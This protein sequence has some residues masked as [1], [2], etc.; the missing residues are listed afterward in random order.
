MNIKEKCNVIFHGFDNINKLL[1]PEYLKSQH[2][3]NPVFMAGNNIHEVKQLIRNK[4]KD[5]IVEKS[6]NIRR[7]KFNYDELGTPIPVDN[8]IINTLSQYSFSYLEM[9]PDATGWNFSFDERKRFYYEVLTYWNTVLIRLKPKICIFFTWPHN[10]DCLALYLLCKHVYK[11]NVLFLDPVPLLNNHFHLVNNSLEELHKPISEIYLSDAKLEPSVKVRK[12]LDSIRGEDVKSPDYILQIYN[13]NNHNL[14]QFCIKQLYIFYKQLIKGKAF[15]KGDFDW[16]I[17][18]KPFYLPQSQMNYFDHLMFN[19]RIAVNNRKLVRYYLPRCIKPE[20]NRKYL[21]FAAP[22]QPE[23]VTAS[24]SM[25]YEDIFLVLDILSKVI[26]DDWCIYYKEHPATFVESFRGS[27]K[28]DK[29][30]YD[31]LNDYQNIYMISTDISTFEMIDHC[32]AV[33]TVSGTVSWEAINRGKPALS[34]GNAWYMGCKS[35][36]PINTYEDAIAA[37]SEIQNGFRPDYE[38]I[39][40]YAAAIEHIALDNMIHRNYNKVIKNCENPKY[41]MERIAK[42]INQTYK[43]HY[44]N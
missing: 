21:F 35:I 36:F 28:K 5:C 19:L 40:R 31:R 41:E 37:I 44:G 23:A 39:D 30:F 7:A 22:Y 38:D 20:F 14:I 34:F 8:M 43:L 17:N 27:L 16:K 42:K 32:Q 13:D 4:F 6:M 2:N 9:M 18:K 24:N 11:I 29:Y 3:W 26:P 25:A 33:A 15:K 10:Q 1:I 12:Y